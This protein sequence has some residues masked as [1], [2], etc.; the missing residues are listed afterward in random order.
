MDRGIAVAVVGR[1]GYASFQSKGDARVSE[2]VSGE[3]FSDGYFD[4]SAI[5]A[6][7]LGSGGNT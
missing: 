5:V 6:V 7:I 1:E 4:L 3:C 2:R